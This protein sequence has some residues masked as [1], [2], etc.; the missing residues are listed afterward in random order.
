MRLT[1]ARR[2]RNAPKP[3]HGPRTLFHVPVILLQ[4]IIGVGPRMG[5]RSEGEHKIVVVRGY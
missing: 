5:N 3:L 4:Q 2:R 1:E